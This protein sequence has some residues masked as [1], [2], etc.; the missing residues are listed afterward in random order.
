[1]V[2]R[3]LWQLLFWIIAGGLIGVGVL[4]FDVLFLAVPCFIVGLSLLIFGVTRLG[5]ERLWAALLG[6]GLIPALFLLNTIISTPPCPPQGL[7]I[8]ANAPA[9]TSVSCGLIPTSYY[10]LLAGFT[11]IVVCAFVWPVL[12]QHVHR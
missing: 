6:F 12:R 3:S 7:A 1:M 5:T 11:I 10:I 8:P 2:Q 4:G 9:G